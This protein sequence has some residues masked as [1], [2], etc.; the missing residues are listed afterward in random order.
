[1]RSRARHVAAFTLIELLVV[2][3]IIAILIGLLLPALGAARGVAR[4][5]VC[6]ATSKQ[7]ATGQTNYA[8]ENKDYYA[9]LATS[10]LGYQVRRQGSSGLVDGATLLMG[11]TASDVPTSTWD[12]ISPALGQSM[13][14]SPN[15]A[16]R[17]SQIFNQLKCAAAYLPYDVIYPGSLSGLG[18]ERQDWENVLDQGRFRQISYLM[19]A[20]FAWWP[21]AT[22]ARR[23][24]PSSRV[25]GIAEPI[26]T[27]LNSTLLRYDPFASPIR[28]PERWEPRISS[29]MILSPASKVM[30]ADG[31]RYYESTGSGAQF[32]FDPSPNPRYYSS[33]CDAGPQ[34]RAS[35]AYGEEF[36]GDDSGTNILLSFRH[37]NKRFNVTFWDG[38]V[39]GMSTTEAW[40]NPAPWVPSGSE[41]TDA[42]DLPELARRRFPARTKIQ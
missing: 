21:S 42:G 32:D 31:S 36:P 33:F 27:N 10:G 6:A 18:A 34:Y 5:T 14:L 24:V 22:R 26:N 17:T 16:Q 38:S 30:F 25:T 37:P 35:T 12:W 1:M 29:A 3:A 8:G 13:D 19:P 4:S 39:R 40:S 41:V 9:G 2:I 23:D 7:L 20:S 11:T 28:G 15:R